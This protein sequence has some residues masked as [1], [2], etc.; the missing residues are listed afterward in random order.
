MVAL[1]KGTRSTRPPTSRQRCSRSLRLGSSAAEDRIDVGSVAHRLQR[2]SIPPFAHRFRQHRLGAALNWT[3]QCLTSVALIPI[4]QFVLQ[5][6]TPNR[7]SWDQTAYCWIP[8]GAALVQLSN[9]DVANTM[10]RPSIIFELA[11]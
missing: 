8:P 1:S 11:L 7:V 2:V 9:D 4:G 5:P 10:N 3:A 6:A